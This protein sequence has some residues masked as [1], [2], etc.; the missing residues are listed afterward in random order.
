M[1]AEETLM[2]INVLEPCYQHIKCRSV[3]RGRR[4]QPA[5]Q[6]L[7]HPTCAHDGKMI[8]ILKRKKKYNLL[9]FYCVSDAGM[10]KL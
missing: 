8:W 6:R 10:G 4:F 9:R 5:R 7:T 2:F 3:K 1:T